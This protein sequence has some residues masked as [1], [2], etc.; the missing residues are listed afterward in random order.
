MGLT[1]VIIIL[2][3][4]FKIKCTSVSHST[5]IALVNSLG[6]N[7]DKKVINWRD[8]ITVLEEK[9]LVVIYMYV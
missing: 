3:G 1:V 8:N 2:K 4:I 9:M 7:H 6:K 5:V